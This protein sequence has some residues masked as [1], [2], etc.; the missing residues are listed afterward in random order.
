ME[1]IQNPTHTKLP[2]EYEASFD[3]IRGKKGPKHHLLLLLL[4]QPLCVRTFD[5][6]PAAS[7]KAL[8]RWH[9]ICPLLHESQVVDQQR[10][11]SGACSTA[12]EATAPHS[13]I[14]QVR[15]RFIF[16]LEGRRKH[17]RNI[18]VQTQSSLQHS[19]AQHSTAQHSTPHCIS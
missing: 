13:M 4:C 16:I 2:P 15:Q 7:R 10:R 11:H 14:P 6:G 3:A 8:G 17:A 1:Q 9:L 19:T 12:Q 5:R 18:N